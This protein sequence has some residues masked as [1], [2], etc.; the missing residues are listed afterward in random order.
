VPAAAVRLQLEHA[1]G[2]EQRPDALT[3][4]VD[5]PAQRSEVLWQSDLPWDQAA[6]GHDCDRS[7]FCLE[8]GHDGEGLAEPAG[9]LAD[10]T[11]FY[12][13]PAGE[14]TADEVALAREQAIGSRAA[15]DGPDWAPELQE[16]YPAADLVGRSMVLEALAR[17]EAEA[18]ARVAADQ[19]LPPEL[20]ESARRLGLDPEEL[21]WLADPR[22]SAR[23]RTLFLIALALTILTGTAAAVM[24]RRGRR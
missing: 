21:R 12:L 3:T 18:H 11:P 5:H 24:R 23:R 4:E 15:N 6:D 14:Y 2:D 20:Q 10:G 9:R 16:R 22:R 7:S 1:G 13:G 17:Q 8:F 19:A